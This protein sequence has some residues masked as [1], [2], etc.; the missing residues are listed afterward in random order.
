[1][2]QQRSK[3][4]QFLALLGTIFSLGGSLTGLIVAW[5]SLQLALRK[6]KKRKK[7]VTKHVPS[8]LGRKKS[9]RTKKRRGRT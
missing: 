5:G 2:P 6:K 9:T 3:Q 4:D 7:D 1:M 8:R